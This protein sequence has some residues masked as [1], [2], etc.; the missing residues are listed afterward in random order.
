MPDRPATVSIHATAIAAKETERRQLAA[1][2]EAFL[3]KRGN[4]IQVLPNDLA[5]RES[6]D[7]GAH[8]HNLVQ[9]HRERQAHRRR[10]NTAHA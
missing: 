10:R 7:Y 4:R 6:R 3:R 9:S 1:D 8:V 5:R 2:V